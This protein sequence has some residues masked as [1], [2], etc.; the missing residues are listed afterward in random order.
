M[1]TEFDPIWLAVML[2][3]A[4]SQEGID[5]SSREFGDRGSGFPAQALQG[6]EL[7]RPERETGPPC[8]I[9]GHRLILLDLSEIG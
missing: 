5:G 7:V 2:G 9:A 3:N 8:Y 4:S 6:F 1:K